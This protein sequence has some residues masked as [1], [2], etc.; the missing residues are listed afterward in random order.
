MDAFKFLSLIF[1]GFIIFEAVR[2]I[3]GSQKAVQAG[4]KVKPVSQSI[5]GSTANLLVIG[6]S[7]SYGTGATSQANS[8]VG[9]LAADYSKIS[10]V[11]ASENAMNVAQVKDKMCSMLDQ[12]FDIV[13][14]HV[15]GIDSL[16]LTPL[17]T[18]RSDL[19][20]IFST[21][22]NMGAKITVLVSVNNVGS[23]PLFR[24]PLSVMYTYRSR[25]VSQL[26]DDVCRAQGALHVPLFTE[27]QEE[28]L[29]SEGGGH[30]SAD[31]IHPNDVGYKIWYDKIQSVVRPYISKFND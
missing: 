13:M 5:L 31:G 18:L 6:D 7:T 20:T 14:I 12:K 4:K 21:A 2:I 1:L 25:Q 28:P 29:F 23:V 11:N 30:F 24:F 17:D 3:I 15:G 27:V 10:I 22:N 26:C 9:M 19:E 8:L 16:K